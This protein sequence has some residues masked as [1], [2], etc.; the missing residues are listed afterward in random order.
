MAALA[1]PIVVLGSLY[2]L[3]EQEK[4]R[5]GFIEE[6]EKLKEEETFIS[7]DATKRQ[8][9]KDPFIG[10]AKE[11]FTN[12]NTRKL[13]DF[14]EQ[15][16]NLVNSYN[17]SNQHT[18]KFFV[19]QTKNMLTEEGE[20]MA[21]NKFKSMNG[22]ELDLN[23]FK[24]NNMKP[25]FGAKI[26]G[27]TSDFNNTE[28]ILD[29]KTGFGS[30]QFSK[31]EQAPLFKP[32]EH[33]NFQNGTPNNSDFFQS[34]VN[35][36]MKMSNVTLWEQQRVAPG[37]NLGYGKQDEKGFNTGGTEGTGGFNNS[38]MARESWMPKSVDDL[39]VANNQKQSFDLNGH[40]GPAISSIKSQGP[41]D[42][43]GK[44]EKHLP[45]KYYEAGP[46]RWFTTTG[47]EQAPPI[48][49][50]Q[51]I[52]ME[53][54]IDSTREYYGAGGQRQ[55]T[56]TN[57]DYEESKK[58]NLSSLPISNATLE[59]QGSAN[60]NDYGVTGY[61][62]LPNNRTTDRDEVQFGGVYGMAKAVI[63]PIMDMLNPTRK[64]NVIGNLRQSGNVNGL[65]ST[66]HMFNEHDKT[67]V[68]NR[69]MTTGKIGLNHVNVQA[70]SHRGDGY[71]VTKH[72]NY[73]NQ[74]TTTNQQHIGVGSSQGQGVRTYNAAYAQQN[75]VNKTYELHAN[76]GN[77]SLFNHDNNVEIKRDEGLF[78]NNRGNVAQGGPN[79]I[80]STEFM[81]QVNGIQT[82]DNTFNN[83][84]MDQSLLTAFKN[85]PYTKSLSSVA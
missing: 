14:G 5:E 21:S 3:N 52:P 77:M 34:R 79:I 12:Y 7:G 9:Q 11:G 15:N 23:N 13:D 76:Q 69:E 4:K 20:N 45:E 22:Q 59:G 81:G 82:Y 28:S 31:S 57:P 17:N 33:T 51:V 46:T 29:S 67:K 63:A 68:T 10:N 47:I 58:I 80:P 73:N 54:R 38:M 26:R 25:F 53:N 49:S 62:V 19:Q 83:A 75:N 42:R 2:I 78:N 61:N 39:R 40:Q 74:R 71:Q 6:Q 8:K 85:N 32:D 1:I 37:L 48:R 44:I 35:E 70:Q 65:L 84:R 36:S 41:N 66:G 60:P 56:Y 55:T 18:D 50:T 24:H 64:V 43:I 72:Q 27:A 16:A 30:Q